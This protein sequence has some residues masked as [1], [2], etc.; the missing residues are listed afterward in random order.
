MVRIKKN[1]HM[2]TVPSIHT[3]HIDQIK[4]L[5]H[6]H[7][8]INFLSLSLFRLLFFFFYQYTDEKSE[9]SFNSHTKYEIEKA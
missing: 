8:S 1:T 7:D 4:Y 2:H 5:T 6:A 3:R 9:N